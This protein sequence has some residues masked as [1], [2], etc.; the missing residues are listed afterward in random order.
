MTIHDLLRTYVFLIPLIVGLSAEA[1]K[2][3][4]EGFERGA[5][6][7]GLFRPGGMPSSHSALVTSLLIIVGY[8][9]GLDSV[10]FAVAFVFASIVWY[11]AMSSRRAIGKQAEVLN[12]LQQWEHLSERLGHSFKEVLGGIAYGAAVTL[13]GIWVAV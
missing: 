8:R 10:L 4:T 7:E 5:W 1:L 11:D 12:R 13:L 3:M 2:I 6:H 9:A